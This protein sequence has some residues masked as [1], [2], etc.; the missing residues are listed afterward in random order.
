MA[1]PDTHF[2]CLSNGVRVIAMP[3]PHL[4]T[5]AVSVFVRTGSAHESAAQSGISHVIEHMAFKGTAERDV[6]RINL[7]AERLGAEVNAHTDKDHTAYQMRGL[8]AHAGDF[9]RM[10]GDIVL[11]STFP[12]AELERERQVLL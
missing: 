6:R 3:M 5:A 11:A 2:T 7:D 10:L 12:E 1:H 9:V 8:A 4:H